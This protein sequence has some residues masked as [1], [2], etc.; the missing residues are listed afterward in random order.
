MPLAR[1]EEANYG[2][3]ARSVVLHP[4][5]NFASGGAARSSLWVQNSPSSAIHK[6]HDLLGVVRVDPDL[7][8]SCAKV[9]EKRVE[10]PVV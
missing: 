5:R 4:E 10:V 7:F 3:F 9:L 8:Q 2:G 6:F 1:V